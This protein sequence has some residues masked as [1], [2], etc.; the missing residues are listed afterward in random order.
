[1]NLTL[2]QKEELI[3]KKIDLLIA[4]TNS[5]KIKRVICRQKKI[6]YKKGLTEH[7]I[8]PQCRY[9]NVKHKKFKSLISLEDHA[10]YH[11][12]FKIMNPFEILDALVNYYW[13]CGN[14]FGINAIKKY[15]KIYDGKKGKNIV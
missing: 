15:I 5:S 9:T 8:F 7:H 14:E 12:L 2:E 6:F 11:K 3:F 1:M 10:N 4:N 13:D